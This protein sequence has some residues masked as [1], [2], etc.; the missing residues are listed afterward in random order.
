[1]ADDEGG[2]DAPQIKSL[3][4]REDRRQHL[5][6]LGCGEHEFDVRGRF[7]QR[8]E[9]RVEGLLGEHVDF[10]DDINLEAGRGWG[11]LDRLAQLAHFVNSPVAGAVDFHYVHRAALGDLP[12]MRIIVGK[13][14]RR[15]IGAIEALGENAGDGRLA[16]PAGADKQ[17]GVRDALLGDGVGERLRDVLLSDDIGE[18][19]RPVF[20][21]YDLVRHFNSKQRNARVTTADAEQTAAAAFLPS[22]GS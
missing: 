14:D 2:G 21:R 11:V 17:V 5:L 12:G 13:I 6:R 19:L 3:A 20:A 10:V 8:F 22:R 1:M 18:T 7:L 4:A 9:Q 16:R 15:A